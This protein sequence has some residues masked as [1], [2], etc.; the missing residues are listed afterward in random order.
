MATSILQDPKMTEISFHVAWDKAI[1]EWLEVRM[2]FDRFDPQ[3]TKRYIFVE[4]PETKPLRDTTVYES[5]QHSTSTKFSPAGRW[6]RVQSKMDSYTLDD[7]H[8][9]EDRP[10]TLEL[11][12]FI[13][14]IKR[15][16]DDTN[17]PQPK[18][19]IENEELS[20]E[21][22]EMFKLFYDE[23][24]EIDRRM[25]SSLADPNTMLTKPSLTAGNVLA[26][27]QVDAMVHWAKQ[28]VCLRDA[29]RC[30]VR[31]ERIASREKLESIYTRLLD[32]EATHFEWE[33]QA[34]V[35]RYYKFK[36]QQAECMTFDDEES[37][38]VP[39][40]LPFGSAEGFGV[41]FTYWECY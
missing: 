36:E 38:H 23:R 11:C 12:P 32:D 34:L 6:G 31:K 1:L 27:P 17:L 2:I 18:L 20:F 37:E 41:G 39:Y 16:V 3:N 29:H 13:I 26:L 8:D 33:E 22:K 4:N 40:F 25:Q 14:R 19:D 15:E 10:K 5:V 9:D 28:V 21:W 24:A 30:E 35:F 7:E